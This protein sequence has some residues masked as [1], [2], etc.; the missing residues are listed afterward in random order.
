MYKTLFSVFLF[1]NPLTAFCIRIIFSVISIQKQPASSKTKLSRLPLLK[2]AFPFL[3]LFIHVFKI[4][5]LCI[6]LAAPGLSWGT[7]DLQFLLLHVE[8]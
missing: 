8:P 4:F 7:G 3:I 1:L 2:K 6:Y 5:Y